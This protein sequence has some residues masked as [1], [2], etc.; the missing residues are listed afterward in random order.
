MRRKH[1]KVVAMFTI[2]TMC[3][4]LFAGCRASS[5]DIP[6]ETAGTV[7]EE[8]TSDAVESTAEEPS[9][10]EP[11]TEEARPSVVTDLTAHYLRWRDSSEEGV[12]R[13]IRTAE[14]YEAYCEEE[15]QYVSKEKFQ[16]IAGRFDNAF[17]ENYDLAL[18]GLVLGDS[19]T[20]LEVLS[21]TRSGF[22]DNGWWYINLRPRMNVG[23]SVMTAWTVVVE[24][25]E[26]VLKEGETVRMNYAQDSDSIPTTFNCENIYV[27]TDMWKPKGGD[28]SWY[29]HETPLYIM[30]TKEEL[31]AYCEAHP[32]LSE[33]FVELCGRYDDQFWE[34]CDLVLVVQREESS[35][36]RY[37]VESFFKN[38]VLSS[39]TWFLEWVRK[40]PETQADDEAI[41]H[42]FVGVDKEYKIAEKHIEIHERQEL[43]D[44]Q[45]LFEVQYLYSKNDAVIETD[46]KIRLI[47]SQEQL[48]QFYETNK[49]KYNL[50]ERWTNNSYE[51]IREEYNPVFWEQNDLILI[52]L[53]G[54]VGPYWYTLTEIEWLSGQSGACKL[55]IEAATN[56]PESEVKMAYRHLFVAVPKGKVAEPGMVSLEF[57]E[58]E[59]K[60]VD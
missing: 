37:A 14:E 9:T 18:T 16:A 35:S 26:G 33:G 23:N 59:V 60:R 22:S 27:R 32:E 58:G 1:R 41:W 21:M 40:I 42:F 29:L 55:T 30:Q 34:K 24:V 53:E 8:K 36:V 13:V 31:K 52:T 39:N 25:P 11:T 7:A 47:S 2:L 51:K 49:D 50:T 43:V 48:E 3:L 6:T 5:S 19:G 38:P 10:A 4:L 44:N 57:V 17:W 54:N 56:Y 45:D 12:T 28:E 46:P 20:R 15:K